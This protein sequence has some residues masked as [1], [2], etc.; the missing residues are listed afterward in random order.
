MQTICMRSRI[1]ISKEGPTG[2]PGIRRVKNNNNNSPRTKAAIN[3]VV[4]LLAHNTTAW[5]SS[6]YPLESA[7]RRIAATA[8]RRP[9]TVACTCQAET[10]KNITSQEP[11]V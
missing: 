2:I 6:K 7:P 5:F 4:R 1:K 3:A 9:I 10:M 11:V 8:A